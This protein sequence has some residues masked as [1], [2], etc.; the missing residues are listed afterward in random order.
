[1]AAS[2][3][4]TVAT[5]LRANGDRKFRIKAECDT[6]A[7]TSLNGADNIGCL[8]RDQIVGAALPPGRR[9]AVHG[10]KVSRSDRVSGH[11]LRGRLRRCHGLRDRRCRR[12]IASTFCR[13]RSTRPDAQCRY[14]YDDASEGISSFD[15]PELSEFMRGHRLAQPVYEVVR[16]GSLS[17][18]GSLTGLV[19]SNLAL[20]Q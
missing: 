19:S 12:C 11:G 3:W 9:T 20:R 8:D 18:D 1:M 2:R 4:W 6:C 5:A 13:L 16:D 15:R 14:R 7:S 17:E 10:V